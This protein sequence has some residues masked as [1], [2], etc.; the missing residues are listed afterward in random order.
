MTQSYDENDFDGIVNQGRFPQTTNYTYFVNIFQKINQ[1]IF[2]GIVD[3]HN[4][5]LPGIDGCKNK[6]FR[7]A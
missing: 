6:I 4:H 1:N 7:N 3:F 5:V 2:N